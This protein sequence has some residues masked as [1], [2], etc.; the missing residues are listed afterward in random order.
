MSH[1]AASN[2]AIIRAFVDTASSVHRSPA[3]HKRGTDGRTRGV[4]QSCVL[5][6]LSNNVG[7]A[8]SPVTV[9]KTRTV[10]SK[11]SDG[12]LHKQDDAEPECRPISLLSVLEAENIRLRQAVVELS[13]DTLALR[14]ALERREASDRVVNFRSREPK[15]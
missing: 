1:G 10:D 4:N 7:V 8:M 9:L 2:S 5:G 15:I 6:V 14:E 12:K 11:A 3:R 13:L